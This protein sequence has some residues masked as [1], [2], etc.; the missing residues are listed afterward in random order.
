MSVATSLRSRFFVVLLLLAVLLVPDIQHA[1]AQDEE[2]DTDLLLSVELEAKTLPAPPS[3]MR[4]VRITLDPGATSPVHTHPGPEFGRIMSGVVTVTVT[5]PAKIK[6]RSAKASD[7]FEDAEQGKSMQLDT[8]DQIYYPAGTPL[9]FTN[10]GD[11]PASLLAL[12]ILPAESDHAP[13]IEYT[14]NAPSE[15]SFKGLTSEILG[16]AILTTLPSGASTITI[17]RVNL[18][19]GQSLPGSRNPVLYS[20]VDGPCEFK[21]TGGAVQI[22]RTR[23]PGPQTAVE[24]DKDLELDSGDAMFFPNG[25]RTTSRGENSDDLKLLQVILAPSGDE[26]LSEEN[27][28][29]LRFSQPSSPPEPDDE[30]S[31]ESTSEDE[32]AGRW[33]E[34]DSVYVNSTDVNLRDAPSLDSGQVTVL[35]YG[36]EMIIDGEPTEADGFTW[37]PVH[38]AE[39]PDIAG[40]VADEFIQTD[41][42]E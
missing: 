14:G 7:P 2:I 9:T 30:T 28:G 6:Q 35:V 1:T 20:V 31:D 17:R 18:S 32:A 38:I 11:E 8:G 21:V 37:W 19:E 16:D 41:P 22:S 34:G 23:E 10:D 33:S 13:L 24:L 12:V 40:Y 29:Q 25:V 5:G 27:R 39:S 26:R 15:D 42:A 3:F 4:L 36:Q